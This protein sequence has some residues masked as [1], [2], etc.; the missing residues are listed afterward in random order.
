MVSC[1]KP[2]KSKPTEHILVN[3]YNTCESTSGQG[4]PVDEGERT[5]D[6]LGKNYHIYLQI[7]V[8]KTTNQKGLLLRNFIFLAKI[9]FIYAKEEA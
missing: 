2:K 6:L 7:E 5:G 1:L 9:V 8:V 4:L 3:K